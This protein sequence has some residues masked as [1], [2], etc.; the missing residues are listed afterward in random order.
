M[1][2]VTGHFIG[3]FIGHFAGHFAGLYTVLYRRLNRTLPEFTGLDLFESDVLLSNNGHLGC[4]C[5]S[6]DLW[7]VTDNNNK[8]LTIHHPRNSRQQVN[9]DHLTS[10]LLLFTVLVASLW[11]CQ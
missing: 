4:R 9:S 2:K 10:L 6:I 3:H 1:K 5:L 8:F 11:A 7:S